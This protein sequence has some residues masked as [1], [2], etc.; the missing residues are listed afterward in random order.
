MRWAQLLCIP[1][2]SSAIWLPKTNHVLLLFSQAMAEAIPAA[3]RPPLISHP[4][5]VPELTVMRQPWIAQSSELEDHDCGNSDFPFVDTEIVGDQ[6]Y[7]LNVHKST[8]PD[9][10]NPR[11]LKEVADVTA[12]PHSIIYQRSWES[13]EVPADWKLASVIPIY[14]KGVREDPGIYRPEIVRLVM[15]LNWEVLLT[16]SRDK[17][18]LQRDLDR[19]EHWAIINGMKLNKN[20]C[21]ILQLGWSK[22]GHKSKLGE[23]W[24]ESS[25][26]ERGLGV[27]VDRRLNRSQQR[28]LAAKRANHILGCI[29]HSISSRSKEVIIPLHL[30]PLQPHLEYPVLFW[31]HH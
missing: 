18:A 4:L 8:R 13:G 17:E 6:L 28:G 12:G 14:R 1:D 27:L 21:R 10:I 2:A 16:L 15:I 24:L 25:P 20:T 19:W 5:S 11:V 26:A 31:P 22:A 23:Q 29:K 9:G 3:Q 30:E 7:Q